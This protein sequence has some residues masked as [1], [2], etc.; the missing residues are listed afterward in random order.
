MWYNYVRN[1]IIRFLLARIDIADQEF[2]TDKD[3]KRIEEWLNDSANHRGF[4]AYLKARDRSTVQ[5]M[6]ALDVSSSAGQR[7]YQEMVGRRLEIARLMAR[8]QRLAEQR[9]KKVT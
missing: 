9:R 6:V 3:Q 5:A 1:R 4:H 8:A 7:A 2:F